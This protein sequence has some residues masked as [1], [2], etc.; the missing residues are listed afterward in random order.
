MPQGEGTYGSKV[1][2]PSN[3]RTGPDYLDQEKKKKQM[4]NHTGLAARLKARRDAT[5]KA[6]R[7]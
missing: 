1:G 4:P 5:N 2:R 6:Q 7:K 3:R